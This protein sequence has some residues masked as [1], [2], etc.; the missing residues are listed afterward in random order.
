MSNRIPFSR[1]PSWIRA[2]LGV[3]SHTLPRELSEGPVI[4]IV[5][6]V[7]GGWGDAPFRLYA[8]V[9]LE[10]S[11]G[12]EH[13]IVP[14]LPDIQYVVL[15]LAAWRNGGSPLWPIPHPVKVA[16]NSGIVDLK[17]DDDIG[18]SSQ[19]V[20]YAYLPVGFTSASGDNRGRTLG[21]MYGLPKLFPPNMGVKLGVPATA[22]GETVRWHIIIGSF[23]AGT[24]PL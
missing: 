3:Q 23:R 19:T 10:N 9:Q 12:T 1:I 14:A 4:P 7:Q 18:G 20:G 8:G 17:V 16:E 6:V 22:A 24:K 2:A 11:A 21:Q 5:D 15:E 13:D